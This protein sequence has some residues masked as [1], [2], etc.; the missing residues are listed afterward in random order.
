V[1]DIGDPAAVAEALARLSGVLGP[2]DILINNAG[3]STNP[4]LDRTTPEAGARM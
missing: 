1:V 2:V 3:V 4:A